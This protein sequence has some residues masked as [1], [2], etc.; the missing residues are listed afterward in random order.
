MDIYRM[1]K[2]GAARTKQGKPLPY[3]MQKGSS[4]FLPDS[5]RKVD[6]G[7]IP[8]STVIYSLFPSSS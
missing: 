7:K 1:Y 6:N 5:F 3:P 8:L 4:Y 2:E